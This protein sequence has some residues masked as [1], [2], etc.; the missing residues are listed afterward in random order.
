NLDSLTRPTPY[1]QD[2]PV[3]MM[4]QPTGVIPGSALKTIT[5]EHK[6]L[7]QFVELLKRRQV[8]CSHP[9]AGRGTYLSDLG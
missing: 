7:G 4:Y 8:F 5:E 3:A 6:Y 1:F 9:T 2:T